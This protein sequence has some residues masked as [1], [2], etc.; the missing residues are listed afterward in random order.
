M[1]TAITPRPLGPFTG[2]VVDLTNRSL[3]TRGTLKRARS[4]VL[5]GNGKL[6][7]KGGSTLALT[8]KDDQGSPA[9]VTAV[10]DVLPFNDGALAIAHSTT[11]NKLYL[12]H[13]NATLTGWYNTA[14]ALQSTLLPE[15]RAILWASITTAPFVLVAEGLGLAYIAHTEAA[16]GSALAYPT[17]VFNPSPTAL[18]VTSITRAGATATLTAA[19][20][21]KL[22]TGDRVT[23][24]GA[25][26]TEYNVTAIVTVTGTTTFTYAVSGTPASPATGTITYTALVT[27]FQ[28]DL[29]ASGAAEDIY[30]LGVQSFKNHLWYWGF[31]SGTTAANGYRP[32]LARFSGPSFTTPIGADSITIGDRVRSQREKIIAGTAVGDAL[33]LAGPFILSRVTGAGR[34]SWFRK[35]IGKEMYGVVGPKAC[36]AAGDWFYAWGPRGPYRCPEMGKP[37]PLWEAITTAI[38]A[39]INTSRIVASFDEGRDLVRFYYDA[40]TGVRTYC[41][42]H[43]VRNVWLGPDDDAGL[44]IRAAATIA[45]VYASTAAPTVGPTGAPTTASTTAVTTSSATANWTAGDAGATTRIEYRRQSDT[46]WTIAVSNLAAGVASY[47]ITGLTSNVAYEWRAVHIKDGIESSYLGPVAGSQFTTA[48][49]TL[50]GPSGLSLLS[51][52]VPGYAD[53]SAYWTNGE[54]EIGTQTE[55]HYAGPSV[56]APGAGSYVLAE[57]VPTPGASSTSGPPASIRVSTTGRYWV[58]V[59][60]IRDGYT[61]SAFTGAVSIDVTVTGEPE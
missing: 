19:A 2:G 36:C 7:A 23:V 16:D 38:A 53:I 37:E 42:Y 33:F 29:D 3:E 49:T 51:T 28:A 58:K 10:C 48:A 54:A 50:T 40:G 5:L 59:R 9:N 46:T 21:H 25:N 44:A 32:E 17:R 56:G 47:G 1:P 13:L 6:A 27:L 8:L 60:H 57:T 24:A 52:N 18:S 39:A 41:A 14:G 11:T 55:V 30:A 22:R 31:G 26:E 61:E 35:Q 34:A 43:T 45:P 15:P 20:A 4:L 12:Y